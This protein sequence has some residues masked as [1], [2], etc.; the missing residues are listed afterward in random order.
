MPKINNNNKF[1][2]FRS[3][4]THFIYEGFDYQYSAV[5][6]RAQFHFNL[7]DKYSFHPTLIIP[8]KEFFKPENLR[9][10]Y[11]ENL[12]FNIGMV[13]MVSYWKAA[14]SPKII[15]KNYYLEEEQLNW[16]K[17]LYFN[18][19]GE[20]FYLNG[21]QTTVEDFVTLECSGEKKLQ[22]FHIKTEDAAII[23]IGGGKDSVVTLELLSQMNGSIPLILNPRE[24]TRGTVQKKGIYYDTI[25]EVMR[26]IDPTLIE[27]NNKG[28]LNGHTPFSALL[29]FVTVL[30]AVMS[31]KKYIALSNE[32]SANEDTVMGT[33]INHQYS[34]SVEFESDF[35]NY[36]EKYI[37]EDIEYFSFLRP[38][39]EL[40]I[41]NL[42]SGF[43]AYFEVFRSCNAGSKN[44]AWCGKCSKCL[45]T[46]LI[47]SPFIPLE[48]LNLIFGKNMLEDPSL[49]EYFN[50]LTGISAIKPFDC[51]G[52]VDEVNAAVQE[53]MKKFAEPLPFLLQQYKQSPQYDKFRGTEINDF[54]KYYDQ[55]HFLPGLF[56]NRLK[57]AL[58]DG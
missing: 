51:V 24:A 50:E 41:A 37:C 3:K 22:S 7:S 12:L 15:I 58:H 28:F 43:P 38:L 5:G 14:C 48:K 27:L 33:G 57:A 8:F 46:Y 53:L 56:E 29:A 30:A 11:L 40:Q 49:L 20:F 23:P 13:E 26:T 47:L 2:Q 9:E 34:K 54:L 42:F 36:L 6:L 55:N 35:R 31:G 17:K 39:N 44:N 52:T 1:L 10:E 16:W 4:F 45:F 25:A 32:S 19:L 21:I 18:G